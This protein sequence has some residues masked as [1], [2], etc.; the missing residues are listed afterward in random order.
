MLV[1]E[2]WVV[3]AFRGLGPFFILVILGPP[4]SIKTTTTRM[5]RDLVD[6][7]AEDINIGMPSREDW[8]VVAYHNYAL[9][10]DNL[11]G[12]DVEAPQRLCVTATGGTSAKRELYTNYGKASV[13]YLNPIALNSTMDIVRQGDLAQRSLFWRSNRLLR[14]SGAPKRM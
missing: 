8:G 6:P 5:A 2:G 9:A 7:L 4:G 3:A 11:T 10:L 1:F 12:V 14:I 13:R